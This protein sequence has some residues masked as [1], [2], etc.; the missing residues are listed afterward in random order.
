ME[1]WPG[2]G[3]GIDRHDQ[4]LVEIGQNF[5]QHSRGSRRID[6]LPAA[7]IQS[8]DTLH[9][10]AQEF[11]KAIPHSSQSTVLS[12]YDFFSVR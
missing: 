9:C 7:F 3:V 5:L 12:N 2:P 10:A 6:S 11:N 8:L 1:K 4:H